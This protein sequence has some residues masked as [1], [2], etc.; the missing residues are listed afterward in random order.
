VHGVGRDNK[1]P[2][3]NFD[4]AL[5][6]AA[7]SNPIELLARKLQSLPAEVRWIHAQSD[8]IQAKAFGLAPERGPWSAKAD[9][10]ITAA[11]FLGLGVVAAALSNLVLLFGLFCRQFG[12]PCHKGAGVLFV[13]IGALREAHLLDRF[14][15]MYGR[16]VMK[17]NE[18]DLDTF[19]KYQ[20][21]GVT[22]LLREW[23]LLWTEIRAHLGPSHAQGLGRHPCLSYLVLRGHMFAYFRA[24]FRRYLQ[25]ANG[26]RIIGLSAASYVAYAAV[27]AGTDAIYWIHGFQ[28]R[29]LVYP[30]FRQVHCFN[31]PEAEH[32]RKRLPSAAVSVDVERAEFLETRRL[33]AIA[34]DY[35]TPEELDCCRSFI[36]WAQQ[37][38]L[39]VL[40]RPH[41][42]DT[43]GYWER[44]RG[45]NG[46][47]IVGWQCSFSAFLREYRPRVL[48]TWYSTTL[49]D[50]FM[51]GVVPITLNQSEL[52]A[53]D[54]VFPFC[55]TALKWP[56]EKAAV[57]TMIDD[58]RVC[59]AWLRDKCTA[60]VG[61]PT[62][63]IEMASA[64]PDR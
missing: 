63:R 34:A 25:D 2:S 35:G 41:P 42:Q 49:F 37:I 39:P 51:Q 31:W 47:E 12:V 14:R 55:S 19:F 18:T 52:T 33:A 38:G 16:P 59:S 6:A 29:S 50:A 48:V 24:W 32:I 8:I 43:S 40:V 27:S 60:V 17:V 3:G 21:L 28:R 26:S 56:E 58:P 7:T 5:M 46:V 57:A 44:W 15:E 11:E 4:S 22:P 54:V 10:L 61:L 45:V 36:E 1:S 62:G 13:G 30:D 23:W 9:R 53:A 20:R 64:G